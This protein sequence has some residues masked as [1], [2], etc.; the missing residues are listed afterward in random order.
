MTIK[1]KALAILLSLVVLSGIAVAS[2]CSTRTPGYWKNHDWPTITSSFTYSDGSTDYTHTWTLPAWFTKGTLQL[3]VKGDARINLE[4]KVIAAILSIK[5]DNREG[6]TL[7]GHY[8]NGPFN[9]A[10]L[11][12]LITAALNL[13]GPGTGPGWTPG[14][15]AA[16]SG[17]R[18]QGLALASA[19]DYWL[20]YYDEA[21]II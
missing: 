4:Q 19:I 17:V 20:N 8:T 13:I 7:P 10:V 16:N 2:A 6:W 9:G 18:A 12:D 21:P 11:P 3:P 14:S 15:A 5:M 1:M